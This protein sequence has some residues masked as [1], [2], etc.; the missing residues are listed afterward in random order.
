MLV[1]VFCQEVKYLKTDC[2]N[3]LVSVH[4]QRKTQMKLEFEEFNEM[5]RN[6]K[7]A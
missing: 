6:S 1:S 3:M 7:T 4:G 2:V 5:L